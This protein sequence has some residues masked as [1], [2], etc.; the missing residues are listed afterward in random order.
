MV[1]DMEVNMDMVMFMEKKK[2]KIVKL[3]NKNSYNDVYFYLY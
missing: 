2:T 1:M 3:F